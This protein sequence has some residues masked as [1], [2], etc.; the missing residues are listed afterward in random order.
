MSKSSSVW[1]LST[2]ASC[3]FAVHFRR[4]IR[5]SVC[6]FTLLKWLEVIWTGIGRWFVLKHMVWVSFQKCFSNF[7]SWNLKLWCLSDFSISKMGIFS[8]YPFVLIV[9]YKHFADLFNIPVHDQ[10]D[11]LF[12]GV[13]SACSCKPPSKRHRPPIM[14]CARC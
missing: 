6:Y 12:G 7:K 13:F 2:S 1:L 14:R 9:W 4:A 10:Q 8:K 11:I 5:S 3:T